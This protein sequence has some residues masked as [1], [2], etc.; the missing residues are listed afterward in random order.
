MSLR[1]SRRE[2]EDE[3]DEGGA[4]DLGCDLFCPLVGDIDDQ[5]RDRGS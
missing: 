3:L 5:T 2:Q 1:K 4:D